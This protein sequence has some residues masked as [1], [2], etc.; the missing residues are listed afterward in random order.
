MT[1][2]INNLFYLLCYAWNHV[3]EGRSVAIDIESC[4]SVLDLLAHILCNGIDHLLRRGLSHGYF[5]KHE[6]LRAVRGRIDLLGTAANMLQPQGLIACEYEEFSQ[7]TVQNRILLAA[8]HR[9]QSA[10]NL[11]EKSRHRVVIKIDDLR[12]ITKIRLN[13]A[14]FRTLQFGQVNGFYGFL[15]QVCRMIMNVLL[16]REGGT[17]H[18]FRD[19]L[20][21]EEAMWRIFQGFLK[22]F[23]RRHRPEWRVKAEV[24]EWQQDIYCLD[25]TADLEALPKMETDLTLFP[26]GRIVIADAKYY[27]ETLNNKFGGKKTIHSDHLYQLSSYLSHRRSESDRQLEGLLIYPDTAGVVDLS[28]RLHGIPIHVRTLNL[29]QSWQGIESDTLALI[30]RR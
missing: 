12:D 9:L 24:I 1:I 26:P 28:F 20:E 29:D 5:S 15:L 19:L 21:D 16:P 4:P 23:Y 27:K 17:E 18:L 3:D 14:A 6:I 10:L 2:P 7:D 11:T 13:P 8:L 25:R 22:N 30:E